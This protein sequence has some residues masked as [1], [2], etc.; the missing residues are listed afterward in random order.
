MYGVSP[1]HYRKNSLALKHVTCF[2]T[3]W[4]AFSVFALTG[5]LLSLPE[6]RGARTASAFALRSFLCT[7]KPGCA[8]SVRP[9]RQG[10]FSLNLLLREKGRTTCFS[11]KLSLALIWRRLPICDRCEKEYGRGIFLCPDGLPSSVLLSNLF[12]C[13][14]LRT[15]SSKRGMMPRQLFNTLYR[16]APTD[17]LSSGAVYPNVRIARHA[18]PRLRAFGLC[19]VRCLDSFCTFP[20]S[21]AV[22]WAICA[23]LRNA[24]ALFAAAGASIPAVRR[25]VRFSNFLLRFVPPLS[26]CSSR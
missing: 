3:G 4:A 24:V 5:R 13:H 20:I 8:N 21:E 9:F 10:S 7:G 22:T 6:S 19:S 2:C 17:N 14:F 15:F 11:F 12:A 16:T 23:R 1:S 26:R 18:I 25:P